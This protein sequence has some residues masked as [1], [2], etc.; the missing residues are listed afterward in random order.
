MTTKFDK[1]IA[2]IFEGL[3]AQGTGGIARRASGMQTQTSTPNAIGKST[4]VSSGVKPQF[5]GSGAG[6]MGVMGDTVETG[7]YDDAI[8][9]AAVQ[10]ND[11][12]TIGTVLSQRFLDDPQYFQ[13]E[14]FAKSPVIKSWMK[15]PKN[16]QMVSDIMMNVGDYSQNVIK[17]NSLK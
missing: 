14:T 4:K 3:E 7:A 5:S 12:K 9:N 13:S 2:S 16:Q 1:F 15:N 8:F 11:D 6:K 10:K 17:Q